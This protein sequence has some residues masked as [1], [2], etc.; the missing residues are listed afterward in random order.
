VGQLLAGSIDA[1]TAMI[2][3]IDSGSENVQPE[4]R[5]SQT[6]TDVQQKRK[7]KDKHAKIEKKKKNMQ[8]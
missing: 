1:T 6:N 2:V 8:L 7:A 3:T 4:L 5:S